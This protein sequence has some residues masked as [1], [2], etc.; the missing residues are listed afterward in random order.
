M[1]LMDKIIWERSSDGFGW[2][3]RA[4]HKDWYEAGTVGTPSTVLFEC[5]NVSIASGLASLLDENIELVSPIVYIALTM[6]VDID[7]GDE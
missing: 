2:I 5:D 4:M 7:L 1:K 3:V 6:G